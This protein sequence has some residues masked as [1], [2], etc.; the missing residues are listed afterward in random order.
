M[1]AGLARPT[2]PRTLAAT[3][4]RIEG[5]YVELLNGSSLTGPPSALPWHRLKR[6]Q[7]DTGGLIDA[8]AADETHSVGRNLLMAGQHK[9]TD[10]AR[11]R[12]TETCRSLRSSVR[13]IWTRYR[14]DLPPR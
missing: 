11:H 7:R 3:R 4:G 6:R 10:P 5:A 8:S 12:I 1:P 2:R 13:P 9:P 14:A